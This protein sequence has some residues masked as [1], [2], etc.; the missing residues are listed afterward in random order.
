MKLSLMS[1]LE[2]FDI[3]DSNQYSR[4]VLKTARRI[5]ENPKARRS[6]QMVQYFSRLATKFVEDAMGLIQHQSG[7]DGSIQPPPSGQD[8]QQAMEL[9]MQQYGKYL[10][11]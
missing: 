11:E 4:W 1:I 3:G 2:G 7:G 6:P 10:G 5:Q 9:L 8:I